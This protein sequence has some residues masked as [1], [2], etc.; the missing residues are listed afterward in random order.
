MTVRIAVDRWAGMSFAQAEWQWKNGY[1]TEDEWQ[2]Y[3]CA[4]RTS[5]PRFSDLAYEHADCTP[6]RCKRKGPVE[7]G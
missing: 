1:L 4:W 7:N 5:A 2:A 6:G 3:R